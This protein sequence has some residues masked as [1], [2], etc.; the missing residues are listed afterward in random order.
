[1][2]PAVALDEAHEMLVNKDIKT[3]V[4]R[5]SKGYLN[6]IMYYYCVKS[7]NCK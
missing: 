7:K 2:M 4:V 5:P 6:K 3:Y 1:M